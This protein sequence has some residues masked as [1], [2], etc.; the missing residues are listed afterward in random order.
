[1]SATPQPIDVAATESTAPVKSLL[2]ALR[3]L[4][5]FTEATPSWR[6]TDLARRLGMP[7][8]TVSNILT[9][10]QALGYVKQGKDGRYSLGL[11][12]FEL[13]FVVRHSLGLRGHVIPIL[14]EL[15]QETGQIIYLTVPRNGQVLYLEAV[16][17]VKRLVHYSIAGRTGPMH[18][19]GVGKAMLAYLPP[20]EVR[21]I[22]ATRGLPRFTPNTITTPDALEA[23]LEVTR[24]RGYALDRG[25]HSPGV[26]CVAAPILGPGGR[27]LGAISASGPPLYFTPEHIARY[28][29]SLQRACSEIARHWPLL[30]LD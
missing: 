7:K 26:H 5:C 23:E 16:F 17:P 2:R 24:A 8:S 11:R 1:M 20:E 18:C 3:I 19:T 30:N 22:V 4:D 27:L 28:A 25:E 6:V 12:L 9:T 29:A 21:A 10:F 15:Q 13:G 14:E